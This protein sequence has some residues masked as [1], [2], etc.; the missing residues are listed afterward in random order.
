MSTKRRSAVLDIESNNLLAGMLDF[1]SLPYKLNAEASLWTVVIRDL[2]TGEEWFAEKED[3][4]AEWLETTLE[5][6]YHIIAHNGIKFDNIVLMLFGIMEYKIGW[7]D[8]EDTIFGRECKFLDSLILSRLSN[9]DRFGGHS[10]KAWGNRIGE[11]KD[12]Y[13][14]QCIEAG[15]I[16]AIDDKG[17]EFREWNPLMLPYCKQDCKTNASAF[18]H[19][20]QE[21]MNYNWGQ[22]IK[23]EHILANLGIRRELFGFDFDKDFAVECVTELNGIMDDLA[24][25]VEPLLPPKPLGKTHLK[26]WTPPM[27]QLK[28]D[29][30]L[31][32]HMINF[33]SRVGATCKD[34][35]FVWEGNFY[36]IPHTEPLKTEDV[37][38]MKDF[39]HIKMLLIEDF[40][41]VPTEW[42]NR[43]L[44]KDSK[45]V[46]IPI[47]KQIKAL[48]KWWEDTV[49]GKYTKGRMRELD[50]KLD[51]AYEKIKAK[52]GGKWPAR[53]PTSPKIRV[54]VE[55]DLCPNL[56]E[57]GD[58]VQF[59]KDFA[60]WL[61][62]RHRRNSIAGGDTS[63][64]NLMEEDPTSGFLSCYREED[65][66]I[67]TPAI[68][69]GAVT[70]R[71]THIS[72]AN[73]ARPSSIYGKELRSLFRAGEG[74]VFFG[75]DYSSLEARIMAHYVHK[76]PKGIE[77][78]NLFTGEK[79][80][81]WHS[82]QALA[83][84]VSRGDAKSIDYGIL[85]GAQK[86]KVSKMTGK[87]IADAGQL[88][89]DFWDGSPALKDLRD[90]VVKFWESKG[91]KYVIGLDG[92]KINVRSKHALL[93]SL[94]Q[95]A[96]IIYAKYVSILIM[97]KYEKEGLC[98][99][100]FIG[101]PEVTSM[102]E[103]HDEQALW[104]DPKL[105]NFKVFDSKEEAESFISKH[106]GYQ[107]SAISEGKGKFYI[108]LPSIVSTIIEDTMLE[109]EQML[110]IKV[111][112]GYEF[113]VGK[114]W[115][116]CH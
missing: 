27:T 104:V 92:R 30:S 83:M 67:P 113:M 52:L 36:A 62:Y 23:Q 105:L 82:N 77:L 100:P 81:D 76:Y 44:T 98:I 53:V 85:Y 80:N 75:F 103:Y 40:D 15:Y 60:D 33:L 20:M 9:P 64:M 65:G 5:P 19:I 25:K 89:D 24:N 90:A 10:L 28:K 110:K 26:S 45:K 93:N 61:T 108:A 51:T 12:D 22:S 101:Q 38:Q 11:A 115:Y 71:Y 17:A 37:A 78:G 91:K 16:D 43:D 59:A 57:L 102:I 21:Y 109:A 84:G 79:P 4:T 114:S 94:F 34:D 99:D 69:I 46:P 58:K 96:G 88:V 111:P 39:D 68:E 66:R 63:K 42:A 48:D 29:N 31:G 55:K 116:E 72:I 35:G 14:K 8:Q 73:I 70:N 47:E 3:I 56:I 49:G 97:Q 18:K 32:A 1:S 2:D 107:T 54:G 106:E 74:G 86:T 50:M 6:F 95:S 112:M 13:R 7:L 87:S 41:W